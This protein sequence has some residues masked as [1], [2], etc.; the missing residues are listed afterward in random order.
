MV[1]KTRFSQNRTSCY[2]KHT[3][4]FWSIYVYLYFIYIYYSYIYVLFMYIYII[5]IF[6]LFSHCAFNHDMSSMINCSFQI[7]CGGGRHRTSVCRHG[8]SLNFGLQTKILMK[9]IGT[10]LLKGVEIT[11]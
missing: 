2:I 1:E 11:T 4:S 8:I 10:M 9:N 7:D 6:G 3:I 5:Y